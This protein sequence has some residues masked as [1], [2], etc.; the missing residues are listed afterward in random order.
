MTP[1]SSRSRLNVRAKI[2]IIFLALAVIA[3]LIT[4]YVA[5]FSISDVGKSAENSS[6]SLGQGA[7]DDSTIALQ[8]SAE[9]HLIRIASDQAEVTNVLFEN[10]DSEMDILAAAV[11]M[12]ADNPPV[13]PKIS[14][15]GS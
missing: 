14:N 3:L 15:A 4:G 13:V 9:D 6:L 8:T 1:I 10:T 2:L 12:L 5:L 7:V 11:P